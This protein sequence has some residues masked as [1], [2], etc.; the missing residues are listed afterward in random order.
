MQKSLHTVKKCPHCG[1]G[2]NEREWMSWCSKCSVTVCSRC[3]HQVH[4]CKD[5]YAFGIPGRGTRYF[6]TVCLHEKCE[7][8][9][10]RT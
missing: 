2:P 10:P 6:S 8:A 3:V 9:N 4:H 5:G 7:D 1:S